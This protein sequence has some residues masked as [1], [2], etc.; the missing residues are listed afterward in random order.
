MDQAR[1]LRGG[2]LGRL[3]GVTQGTGRTSRARLTAAVAAGEE[4]DRDG[5]S[6]RRRVNRQR[7]DQADWAMVQDRAA[8]LSRSGRVVGGQG[9]A[10]DDRGNSVANRTEPGHDRGR[11]KRGGGSMRGFRLAAPR[12]RKADV[13]ASHGNGRTIRL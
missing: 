9:V 4:I 11:G 8:A 12:R 3:T 7:L 6:S 1:W 13:A 10:L 5:D 2:Q